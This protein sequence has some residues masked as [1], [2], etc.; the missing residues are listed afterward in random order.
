MQKRFPG[1]SS[2]QRKICCRLSRCLHL[3]T[4]PI[5]IRLTTL[6]YHYTCLMPRC[7]KINP[8]KA[9]SFLTNNTSDF[10][11]HYIIYKR[12]FP[13]PIRL[14]RLKKSQV[15]LKHAVIY[16]MPDVGNRNV[17]HRQ[18]QIYPSDTSTRS[19]SQAQTRMHH[20]QQRGPAVHMT[21]L[22]HPDLPNEIPKPPCHVSQEVHTSKKSIERQ[23]NITHF[24][25]DTCRT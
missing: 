19:Q 17:L 2:F 6:S 7:R 5:Y 9:S 21:Y 4:Y 22:Y 23:Q 12:I 15:Q 18:P 16:I 20:L 24:L 11:M 25:T 1:T 10:G 8:S 13:R 14:L 3:P